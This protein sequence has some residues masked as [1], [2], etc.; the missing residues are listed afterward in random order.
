M[1]QRIRTGH[2]PKLVEDL[3]V[4]LS[5]PRAT[6]KDS[7]AVSSAT[8]IAHGKMRYLQGYTSTMLVQ[9]E[10]SG[11]QPALTRCHGDR[12]RTGRAVDAVHGQLHGR[13]ADACG[14]V[15][16]ATMAVRSAVVETAGPDYASSVSADVRD[17]RM[18]E[19]VDICFP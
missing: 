2:L 17:F 18:L 4:R 6:T 14:S 5:R 8:A 3:I 15:A 1:I 11:F 7:D 13:R 9:S 19:C 10:L 16:I 12:G